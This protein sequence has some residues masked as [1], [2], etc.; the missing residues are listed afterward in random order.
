MILEAYFYYQILNSATL[1]ELQI[2]NR[3]LLII[4]TQDNTQWYRYLG[5]TYYEL[6]NYLMLT[7][8]QLAVP[9]VIFSL[10]SSIQINGFP[11]SLIRILLLHASFLNTH[12]ISMELKLSSMATQL[13]CY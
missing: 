4:F 7:T 8:E 13:S 11:G 2:W 3:H 5:Y 12:N 6:G 1:E 9:V 10:E